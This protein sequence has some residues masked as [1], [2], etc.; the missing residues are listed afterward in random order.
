MRK[1]LC[2]CYVILALVAATLLG[3]SSD[4]LATLLG[5]GATG[6]TKSLAIADTSNNRVLIFNVPV[7]T[8]A[9]ATAVLGQPDF[10]STSAGTTGASIDYPVDTTADSSGNLWVTEYNNCRMTFFARPFSNGEA[11]TI[12]LGAPDMTSSPCT[13]TATTLN[14]PSNAAFDSTGHLWQVDYDGSRVL[15][16]SP[17]FST[18]QAADLV[19]GQANLT[20]NGCGTTATTLCT[21]WQGVVFDSSGSIWISD[22]DTCRVLRYSPP[23]STGMAADLVIGQPDMTSSGCGTTA[24]TNDGPYGLAFDRDGNLWMVDGNHNRVLKFAPPFSTGM[25]ATVVIGQPDFTSSTANNGGISAATL[26]NPYDVVFDTSNN[27]Y[28]VEADNHRVLV[29]HPPFATGMSASAVLGQPN[30]TSNSINQGGAAGANTLHS[31]NG[32]SVIN[33]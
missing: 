15:R 30:F 24:T 1:S 29:Y 23:F 16:Y 33:K 8:N 27:M 11:A 6:T 25:A 12:A 14:G 5:G 7:S 20:S 28:V 18:G 32:V 3:C 22:Y 31:P 4:Q 13:V 2:L 21:P 10:T 26:S 9:N 19:L 17:P